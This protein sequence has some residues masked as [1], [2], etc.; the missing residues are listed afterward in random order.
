MIRALRSKPSSCLPRSRSAVSKRPSISERS[1]I[2]KSASWKLPPNVYRLK[3]HFEEV[4]KKQMGKLGPYQCFTVERDVSTIKNHHAPKP[5]KD[6]CEL[7]YDIPAGM[8]AMMSMSRNRNKSMFPKCERF[9]ESRHQD[10]P[11]PTKYYPQNFVIKSKSF[12]KLKIAMKNHLVYYPHTTVPVKEM[13]YLKEVFPTPPP[14]RYDP[15][16]VTCKCYLTGSLNKFPGNVRGDGHRHVFNSRVFRLVRPVIH[17]RPRSVTETPVDDS[18]VQHKRPPREPISFRPKRSQSFDDLMTQG[19]EPEIRYN[20]MVKKRNLFSV[21]T[22][23]PVGFLAAMPRFQ[24]SSEI[25]IKLDKDRTM[26]EEQEKPRRKPITKKRLEELAVPK[27]PRQKIISHKL[28][29]F[30]PL[31]SPSSKKVAKKRSIIES[32]SASA[33]TEI[34]LREKQEQEDEATMKELQV[35]V[36]GTQ[37]AK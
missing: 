5:L 1:L 4:G 30:E 20:T 14:G 18:I 17:D 29:S 22:G 6:I 24:E 10:V 11:P 37:S 23:R 32:P 15:H 25:S 2:E 12:S 31:P 27:N 8:G 21:K 13:S 26:M 34:M 7:F 33:L 28:N 19:R 9:E 36:T 16:D 35:F 3:D